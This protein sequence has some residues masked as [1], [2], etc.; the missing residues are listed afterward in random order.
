M[1][2]SS[3]LIREFAKNTKDEP[4]INTGATVYGT[5]RV[6][7]DGSQFVQIDGS[8][9][10]TPVVSTVE[11]KNGD[12]VTVLVKDHRAIV[13]GNLSDLSVSTTTVE[14]IKKNINEGFGSLDDEIGKTNKN[15]N[16]LYKDFEAKY[17]DIDGNIQSI[18]T[19]LGNLSSTVTG[20]SASIAGAEKIATNYI[21]FDSTNGLIIG[22]LVG[23]TV[24]FNVLIDSTSLNMRYNNTVLAKYASDVIYLGYNSYS[25]KIDLCSG[26]GIIKTYYDSSS[27]YYDYLLNIIAKDALRIGCNEN[28]YG[29]QDYPYIEMYQAD[30]M[31][32]KDTINIVADVILFNGGSLTATAVFG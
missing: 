21:N 2:L 23:S 3:D 20:M 9:T 24:G 5:F 16:E 22:N 10:R 13:T 8:D 27:K 15:V 18:D 26:K 29:S 6:Q 25:S 7:E 28:L 19:K 4:E 30:G 12:R 14:E 11:C 17:T 32:I 31:G 1:E